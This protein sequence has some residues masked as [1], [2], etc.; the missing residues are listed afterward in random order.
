[1]PDLSG[2]LREDSPHSS[3]RLI[4]TGWAYGILIVWMVLS[5][6][7]GQ[8]ATIDGT[9]IG[10]LATLIGGK[11]A[12]KYAENRLPLNGKGDDHGKPEGVG[13]HRP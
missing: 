12:Q 1:M 5:L 6:K 4:A 11:V 7:Q 13:A 10:I 3:M 9:T 2:F 8:M